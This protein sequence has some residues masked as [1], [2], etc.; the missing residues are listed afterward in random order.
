LG[1]CIFYIFLLSLLVQFVFFL[2]IFSRLLFFKEI[3]DEKESEG[4][5]VIVAAHNEKLNLLVLIPQL[6]KQSHPDFEIIIA[7]DRS[8]D[9]TYEFITKSYT[10][11]R[12]KIIRIDQV[13]EGVNPKKNALTKAIG[14]SS[15]ELLLLTDADCQPFS[16]DWIREMQYGFDDKKDIVLGVSPYLPKQGLLN[17]LIRYE[18]LYTAIQYLSFALSGIP[19]MGVGRNLAYRKKIFLSN[20]GFNTHHNITG[21]DDD[22]FIR[23]V[24]KN[25]NVA[26]RINRNSQTLSI[27]KTSFNSWI[28][29]KKR[30]LSVGKYYK[31]KHQI[32]LGLLSISHIMFYLSFIYLGLIQ[33]EVSFI[34]LGFILRTSVFIASFVLILKKLGDNIKWFLLP[35]LDFIYII[36]YTAVG[37]T[38]MVSKNIKWM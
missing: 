20:Q 14:A 2:F 8:T 37:I 11:K 4:I 1:P 31:S 23:D 32:A 22:L 17:L 35:V 38:A 9:G 12:L 34:I 27:P 16:K 13:P 24:S 3:N 5:S 21:G 33:F 18:T 28:K 6:L 26:I 10:D 15:K 19:Y 7:D 25:H 29:Q 30:H 36:Y